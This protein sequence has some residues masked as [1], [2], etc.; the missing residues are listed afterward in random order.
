LIRY[1]TDQVVADLARKMVFV[2]GAR[3]VGKTTFT[4]A[5]ELRSSNFPKA[6]TSA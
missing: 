6:T 2:A 1:L 5:F 4:R 3:Q